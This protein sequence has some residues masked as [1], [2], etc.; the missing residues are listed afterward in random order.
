VNALRRLRPA[1][2]DER[3]AAAVLVAVFISCCLFALAAIT[4]DIARIQLEAQ[5][6]Q[7]AADAAATA[8]VTWMPQDLTQ[9]TTTARRVSGVN[10][11]P[12]SGGSTVTVETAAR[13]SQ[14]K[15]TVT[16]RIPNLF[17]TFLGIDNATVV[18]HAVADYTGPQPMGSP[19][20]TMG[21]EPDGDTTDPGGGS[22]LVVAPAANCPRS[23]QFWLNMNGPDIFKESGDQ[24]SVRTC[25]GGE[26]QCDAAKKN[27]DFLPPAAGRSGYFY[28]VRVGAAAVNQLVTL[29][30]YDPAFVNT[31]DVCGAGPTGTWPTTS[32]DDNP[33][34]WNPYTT[35]RGLERYAKSAGKFCPGDNLINGT[36]PTVTS[37]GLR[38]PTSDSN[39]LNGTPNPTLGCTRQ[40]P[41]YPTPDAGQLQKYKLG[42]TST[43]VPNDT[44][45]TKY[46]D[47]LARVFHQWVKFCSFTPTHAG[48]YYLQVRTN[49][50]MGGAI[51][52]EGSYRP[53]NNAASAMYTQTGDDLGVTGH[54]SNR[55]ALR[56][57]GASSTVS[58]A[59]SVS[60]W[61]RMPIYANADTASSEFNLIRVLPGAAGKT[62]LFQFFDVGDAATNGTMAVVR[63]PD[64]TGD[65]IS[66][67]TG[68]GY[69]KIALPSC[70]ISG[71]NS[72][73]GWNAKLQGILVPIP[74]NYSCDYSKAGGC[75]F[76]VNVSF[77][78]GSVSDTT[79]WTA[80]I[81]GNPVRLIE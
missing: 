28:L 16:S 46:V 80:D 34:S 2:R 49:V 14:L 39:P 43:T 33:N 74:T 9:A 69:K 30:I 24:Y 38:N 75:W 20:N 6:V 79:T 68:T 76:R 60:S 72:A 1:G 17:G 35:V 10:G 51:N 27:K 40:Y 8:G 29:E 56:A 48:D 23:P 47:D 3:G 12:N 11:Y 77:G 78:A 81:I 13:P 5:R 63:P 22:K 21:N 62:L 55:F 71:I 70:S 7:K 65:A 73:N 26:D 15:V 25:K 53:I 37:F 18:R 45:T 50:A 66:N 64:A 58:A 54:G 4:V 61:G 67:C 44:G 32:N 52:D 36:V 42:K 41:G 59:V 19:C 57:Y 31:N